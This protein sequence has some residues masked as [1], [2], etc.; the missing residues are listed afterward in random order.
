MKNSNKA[1]SANSKGI[2]IT[3]G[4]VNKHQ[5]IY[6]NSNSEVAKLAQREDN[7]QRYQVFEQPEF[8]R[9]QKQ[10]YTQAVYGLK[11]YKNEEIMLMEPKNIEEIKHVHNKA[12]VIINNYKQ[13]VASRLAD[14]FLMKMFPN[15]PVIKQM[16]GIQGADSALGTS[17][18]F[19]DL[20]ITPTMMAKKLVE[21]SVLPKNFFQLA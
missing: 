21:F 19:K 3:F 15:S 9:I 2:T 16:L 20:K 13:E 12:K 17:L 6:Y 1:I 5:F 11:A 4:D 14:S 8:N 10:I 18:S 7:R